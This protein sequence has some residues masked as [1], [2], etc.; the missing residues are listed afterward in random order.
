[1]SD[2]RPRPPVL[3]P[4]TF[5]AADGSVRRF[6]DYRPSANDR[7]AHSSSA[8][9]YTVIE[10]FH[11]DLDR[12][13]R[14]LFE[15]TGS[16]PDTVRMA[17]SSDRDLR[18]RFNRDPQPQNDT[19]PDSS[20]IAS[21]NIPSSLPPLRS[22][23]RAPIINA[24]SRSSRYRSV[25]RG[26][27]RLHSQLDDMN[28]NFRDNN[29]DLRALLDYNPTSPR[30]TSPVPP[31]IY[32]L[33]MPDETRQTKRRKLDADKL[34][35]GFKGFQYGQYGQVEPGQL[36][37]EIVSCDGGLYSDEHSYPPENILKNDAS[38][39]CTKGNRCNIIL[40]HQ[41]GTVFSLSEL[42]IKAPGTRFSCPYVSAASPFTT[43]LLTDA[44]RV[45]EGLVFVSMD[46][47]D[48][49][50]RTAQYQ[51]QY[52]PPRNPRRST[53]VFRHDEDGVVSR[54]QSRGVRAYA[55][56]GGPDEDDDYQ[57]EQDYPTAQI[58]RIH[59]LPTP[60]TVTTDYSEVESEDDP[61]ARPRPPPPNPNRIGQLPFESD[62]DSDDTMAMYTRGGGGGIP[63][64][65]PEAMVDNSMEFL[66]GTTRA[67]NVRGRDRLHRRQLQQRRA[68]AL[69]AAEMD[70]GE[71][72]GTTTTSAGGMTLE[73]AQEQSQLATQ[74]AVRAVGGELLAP[75][76]H[77]SMEN[78]RNRCHVKFDP[79]VTGRYVLL[80]M[81]SPVLDPVNKN[82]DIQTVVVKGVCGAEV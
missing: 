15:S 29:S 26:L 50:T 13:S 80:K 72:P 82:I 73:E 47:N 12:L 11:R 3:E 14:Q 20:A 53:V 60:F 23:A 70:I 21:H 67:L 46:S 81:W 32:P 51:I 22:R 66:H 2:N 48:I 38:V 28:R 65:W 69:R 10:Q 55:Y 35:S 27:E 76:A 56:F 9:L 5:R 33:D 7:P 43:S 34:A 49:L 4:G 17:E 18:L 25:N 30:T 41:A 77:F 8:T 78:K 6:S 45:R 59:C 79:P 57:E 75:L 74:E 24:A 64:P 62:D 52:L 58:P 71:L 61:T 54:H 42:V 36:D 31:I 1:M 16:D 39:Y 19:L 37:M 44:P 68:A 40:R 63:P